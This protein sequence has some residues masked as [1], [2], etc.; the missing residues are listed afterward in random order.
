MW[1]IL[2]YLVITLLEVRIQITRPVAKKVDD[3]KSLGVGKTA[4]RNDP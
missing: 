3:A 4:I 2:V 1:K